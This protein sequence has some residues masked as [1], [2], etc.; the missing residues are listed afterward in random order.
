M[1]R[2][3]G[4]CVNEGRIPPVRALEIYN[5][6]LAFIT[7]WIQPPEDQAVELAK[8]MYLYLLADDLDELLITS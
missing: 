7:E 2:S 3:L 5:D 4:V 8:M 6:L 1:L